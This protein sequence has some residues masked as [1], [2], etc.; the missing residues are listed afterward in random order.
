LIYY[1]SVGLGIQDAAAAKTVVGV[2]RLEGIGSQ[3]SLGGSSADQMLWP[4][5]L[6]TTGRRP[7]IQEHH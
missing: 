5:V 2:A 7:T 4:I 6:G 1:N 3:I